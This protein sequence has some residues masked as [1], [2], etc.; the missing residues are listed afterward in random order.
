MPPPRVGRKKSD[1]RS[2]TTKRSTGQAKAL[3]A[4][5]AIAVCRWQKGVGGNEGR[6]NGSE[7]DDDGWRPGV[8]S[9]DHWAINGSRKYQQTGRMGWTGEAASHTWQETRRR[10]LE[11]EAGSE[12][13]GGKE[14]KRDGTDTRLTRLVRLLNPTSTATG[15][16]GRRWI[17]SH[18]TSG[19][20][21]MDRKGACTVSVAPRGLLDDKVG[22][23][24][25]YT[26]GGT[27]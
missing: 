9:T 10:I 23:V 27:W 26:A 22:H 12:E 13:L 11:A 17:R 3:D 5:A 18:A 2:E 16:A 19:W 14:R 1:M 8:R 4:V 24:P 7:D 20:I 21:K 6:K 25:S 15:D